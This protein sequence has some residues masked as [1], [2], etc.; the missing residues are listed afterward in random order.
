MPR[1]VTTEDINLKSYQFLITILN[2]ENLHTIINCAFIGNGNSSL[3]TIG[4]GIN[5]RNNIGGR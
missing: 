4:Q 2:E 3:T 1:N 5:V